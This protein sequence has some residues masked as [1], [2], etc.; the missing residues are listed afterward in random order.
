MATYATQVTYKVNDRKPDL[1]MHVFTKET[2]AAR[3]LTGATNLQFY[4]YDLDNGSFKLEDD[5]NG[6]NFSDAA[7]GELTKEWQ[8]ADLNE[9]GRFAAYFT[10]EIGANLTETTS[11]V[12]INV[13]SPWEVMEN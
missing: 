12:E 10:Y 7:N 2:N 1:V 8:S 13:K 6:V 4:L 9:V 3:V 11:A 5:T